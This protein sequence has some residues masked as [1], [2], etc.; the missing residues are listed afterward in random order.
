MDFKKVNFLFWNIGNLS[1]P[2]EDDIEKVV[3]D[4]NI[5][6]LILAESDKISSSIIIQ[7]TGFTEVDLQL[8][9]R[10]KK[11]VQV[12]Y[13]TNDDFKITHKSEYTEIE[14]DDEDSN[15][16]KIIIPPRR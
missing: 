7:K 9:N 11:W 2:F 13:K 16:K 4:N 14:E 3:T 6:I 12:F 1:S 15:E 10:N 8:K 5:D